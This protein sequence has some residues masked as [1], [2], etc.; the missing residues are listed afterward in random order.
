MRK[1]LTED[2]PRSQGPMT[3]HFAGCHDEPPPPLPRRRGKSLTEVAF[4]MPGINDST[5]CQLKPPRPSP[6]ETYQLATPRTSSLSKPPSAS[7]AIPATCIY[8]QTSNVVRV[9]GFPRPAPFGPGTPPGSA[10]PLKP[11]KHF[12]VY[13][14]IFHLTPG[15]IPRLGTKILQAMKLN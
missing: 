4:Q 3:A 11:I 13:L 10:S 14:V 5:F 6:R 7:P 1:S 15:S 2:P 8:K 9:L 12:L